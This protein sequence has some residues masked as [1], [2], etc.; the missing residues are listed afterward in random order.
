MFTSKGALRTAWEGIRNWKGKK[1]AVD[2]EGRDFFNEEGQVQGSQEA[3]VSSG[4]QCPEKR[5]GS[6]GEREGSL[7]SR[8]E[9]GQLG[10]QEAK[11]VKFEC[12]HCG[13]SLATSYHLSLR[14]SCP[15]FYRHDLPQGCFLR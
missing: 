15:F 8:Q 6:G 13:M 7:W 1:Y 14:D 9:S 11:Q 12:I 5:D 10:N 4:E 2:S 3:M